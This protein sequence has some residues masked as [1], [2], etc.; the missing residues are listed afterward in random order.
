MSAISDKYNAL[1]GP[2]GFLGAPTGPESSTPDGVGRFEHYQ[3]GSIYWTPQTGAHEVHGAIHVKWAALGWENF[4]YPTTDESGTPDGVGRFNHFHNIQNNGDS[5]IYWTPQTGA[6]EVH[7]A[8]HVEWAGLGWEN[9][10]YPTTDESGT[11]DG[12]GRFNHFHNIQNNGDSSIYWTPQTGAHE[13]HGAI[14]AAWAGLGWERSFL[15][16]PT[17]DEFQTLDLTWENSQFQH[18]SILWSRIDWPTQ[19]GAQPHS[20]GQPNSLGGTLAPLGTSGKSRFR[21][22][23][24]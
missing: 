19:P 13:V 8:I 2:T 24:G 12:V 17:T 11:P 9:F 16:Y 14:R 20:A 3:F 5:S 1:G 4:G 21:E 22:Q 6:H 18:G 7:G 23:S 15:G 10:G